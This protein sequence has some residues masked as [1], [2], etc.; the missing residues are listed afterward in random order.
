MLGIT[1]NI[2]CPSEA[3]THRYRLKKRK[4]DGG[5]S[6]DLYK[7]LSACFPVALHLLKLGERD[8]KKLNDDRCGNVRCNAQR[9]Y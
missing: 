2:I 6:C 9:K 7:L 8:G 1:R 3:D 4:T 5:V